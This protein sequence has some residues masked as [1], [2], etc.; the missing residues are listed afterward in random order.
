MVFNEKPA[1]SE[2]ANSTAGGYA[3]KLPDGVSGMGGLHG[4]QYHN[5][6]LAG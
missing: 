6:Q 1:W 4:A 3:E 2:T 5:V